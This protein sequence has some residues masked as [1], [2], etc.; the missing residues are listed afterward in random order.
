MLSEEIELA[1]AEAG[2]RSE[3]PAIQTADE[4]RCDPTGVGAK[5]FSTSEVATFFGKSVQWVYRG[6]R[7]E[8]FTYPD[9]SIIEPIRI[10]KSGRRR[11]TLPV[12]R[13][14]AR[15]CYRRGTLSE[16][17]LECGAGGVVPRR[18]VTAVV[19]HC[20]SRSSRSCRPTE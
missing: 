20:A 9:G 3:A 13:D 12:L 18:A 15:S 6:M 14:M 11:F 8:I 19:P 5:F 10:G 4:Q 7:E 2:A 1:L 16:E 17:R